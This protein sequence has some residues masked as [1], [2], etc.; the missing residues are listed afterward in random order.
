M[1]AT[2]TASGEDAF[3]PLPDALAKRLSLA[4][5]DTVEAIEQPD[6]TLLVTIAKPAQSA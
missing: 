5:G 3:L 4:E 6:P 1:K 2:L